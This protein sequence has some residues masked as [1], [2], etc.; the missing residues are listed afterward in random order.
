MLRQSA[1]TR[2][3][4]KNCH[5]AAE[6]PSR[7]LGSQGDRWRGAAVWMGNFMPNNI[8][9]KQLLLLGVAIAALHVPAAHAR[10]RAASNKWP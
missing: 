7:D 4:E 8:S 1:Q 6:F 5:K 9:H 3:C 2:H 10:I